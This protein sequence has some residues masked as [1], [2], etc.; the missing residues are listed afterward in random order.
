MPYAYDA[1][2]R[3]PEKTR[4]TR[5]SL[6]I[7]YKLP[8]ILEVVVDKM[9]RDAESGFGESGR[10]LAGVKG[11]G[12]GRAPL[13]LQMRHYVAQHCFIRQ[14]FSAPGPVTSLRFYFSVTR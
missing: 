4:A 1:F 7:A 10:L 6:G 2:G 3:L 8:R 11:A 5:I 14:A 13:L 12:M 9:L